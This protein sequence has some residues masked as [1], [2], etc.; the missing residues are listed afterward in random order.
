[1]VYWS[2]KWIKE[3]PLP[4]KKLSAAH[5]RLFFYSTMTD[6]WSKMCVGGVCV[7]EAISSGG[8]KLGGEA[9]LQAQIPGLGEQGWGRCSHGHRLSLFWSTAVRT[10][11]KTQ[12]V[13]EKRRTIIIC[14][15]DSATGPTRATLVSHTS[16]LKEAFLTSKTRMGSPLLCQHCTG[17]RN[18]EVFL[19]T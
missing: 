19:V 14:A 13:V 3:I 5:R 4:S 10:L 1:M 7:W 16:S 18:P 8:K 6:G 15:I 11:N 2:G 17:N 12:Q 9:E